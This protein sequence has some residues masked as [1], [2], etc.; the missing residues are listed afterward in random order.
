MVSNVR[1]AQLFGLVLTLFA[2]SCGTG[3]TDSPAPESPETRTIQSSQS[4]TDTGQ[5]KTPTDKDERIV[6]ALIRFARS[7][8][9]K[10]VADVPLADHGVWLGLADRLLAM[11]SP[12]ELTATAAWV[13]RSK[14]FRGYAGRFSALDLLAGRERMT[15]TLGP[16]PHCAS[17]PVPPPPRVAHLRR[18]SVQPRDIDSCNQWWTVDVFLR[19]GGDIQAVTLDTWEP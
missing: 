3:S 15:V 18:V 2:S 6:R 10:T 17:P 14:L 11:R 4:G 9:P 16:H 13:L 5:G 7:P 19:S 8:G 1:R 12:K